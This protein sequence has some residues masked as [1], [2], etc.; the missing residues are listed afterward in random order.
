MGMIYPDEREQT[1]K[2]GSG[3][4]GEGGESIRE[5]KCTNNFGQPT[6]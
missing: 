1:Q 4:Q 3:Q 2:G 6:K 5:N